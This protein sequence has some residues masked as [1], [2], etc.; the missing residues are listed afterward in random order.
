LR[1]VLLKLL[2]VDDDPADVR[3]GKVVGAAGT[4]RGVRKQETANQE[5]EQR[6]LA[7]N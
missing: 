7:L 2:G 6:A 4:A 5:L 3:P 1:V